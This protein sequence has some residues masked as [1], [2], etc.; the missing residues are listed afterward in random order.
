MY[1]NTFSTKSL[2]LGQITGNDHYGCLMAAVSV[3]YQIRRIVQLTRKFLIL[4]VGT[5]CYIQDYF[6]NSIMGL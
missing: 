1:G 5:P 4:Y 2:N 3:K 6:E